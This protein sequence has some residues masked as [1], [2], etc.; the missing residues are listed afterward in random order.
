MKKFLACL[1]ACLM[2]ASMASCG[3]S[4]KG[5]DSSS[6]EAWSTVSQ[7]EFKEEESK[8]EESSAPASSQADEEDVTIT[9]PA[10]FFENVPDFDPEAYA[11]EQGFVKAE[12]N[13]DGSVTVTMTKDHQNELLS[14]MK[15]ELQKTVDDIIGGDST[16]Y[17]SKITYNDDFTQVVMEVDRE[18]YEAAFDMS[19]LALGFAAMMY[20]RFSGQELHCEVVVKDAATGEA[21]K[22][23]VYPD[24]M[25]Q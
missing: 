16:P 9:L 1:L 2:A 18:A 25:E 11:Q 4:G 15:T 8:A 6:S 14:E 17:I 23:V 19:P 21:I 5:A 3:G 7:A 22:S 12:V 13:D 24:V 20:Q 10:T